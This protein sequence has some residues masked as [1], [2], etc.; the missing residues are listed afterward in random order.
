MN[1]LDLFSGI[2]GF[3]LAARMAR[4]P[5]EKHYYS[6]VADFPSRIYKQHFPE[7]E[8]LGDVQ[9]IDYESLPKARWLICGGF[10]CQD[11][12]NIKHNAEGI[13]GSRSCLWWAMHRAISELRPEYAII[14]NVSALANRGLERVL[15]SLAE[16]GYDAEWR[17]ISARDGAD[18]PHKRERIW[19]VAYPNM[20]PSNGAL[21]RATINRDMATLGKSHCTPYRHSIRFDKQRCQV[22]R[23]FCGQPLVSRVDDGLPDHLDRIKAL[24]NAIVPQVAANIMERLTLR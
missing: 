5:I 22:E 7:A 4:V 12:S 2:G 18:A 14:E 8:A 19:V 10:P 21:Q 15:F 16:I 9:T 13:S 3:A 1:F 23:A 17:T 6:E 11:I 20:P 24:G